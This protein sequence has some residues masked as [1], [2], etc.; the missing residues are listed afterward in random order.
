MIGQLGLRGIS[1]LYSSGDTGVGAACKSNDGKNTTQF[2]PQFPSS[3]PWVTSVGGTQSIAPEVAWINGAGGFSNYF[4]QPDYQKNAIKNYLTNHI[5]N[6]TL[7]YYNH[8]TNVTMRGFP[9]VS[10]H[11]ESP[12]Y[13]IVVDNQTDFAGG[14][15]AACPT[16]SGI[17]ALLNDAR[18]KAGKSALGFLNPWLYSVGFNGLTDII[19]GG[20]V[21]CN[22]VDSQTGVP[23]SFNGLF[24]GIVPFAS[25]NATKGWDPV[26]GLGVP[27]FEKLLKLALEL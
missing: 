17:I 1:V 4:E 15:S 3:C 25:W 10:A 19:S 6:S 11:S 5:S 21:G 16:F 14:T 24:S 2:T 13:I 20:S 23:F 18:F 12:D 9:D 7:S 22:G 27:N 8:F 26:T